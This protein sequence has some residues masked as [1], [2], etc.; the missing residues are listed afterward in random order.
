MAA[1]RVEQRHYYSEYLDQAETSIE[2]A[3]SLFQA[4]HPE[5]AFSTDPPLK[6]DAMSKFVFWLRGSHDAWVKAVQRRASI[7]KLIVFRDWLVRCTYQ[8]EENDLDQPKL[9]ISGVPLSFVTG[10]KM[11]EQKRERQRE[12][13]LAIQ[14]FDRESSLSAGNVLS[15]PMEIGLEDRRGVIAQFKKLNAEGRLHPAALHC[16]RPRTFVGIGERILDE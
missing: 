16:P 6:V 8:L 14:G 11:H 3:S 2:R 10:W 4:G 15:S 13:W 12:Y 9:Y 5:L 7:N 1:I